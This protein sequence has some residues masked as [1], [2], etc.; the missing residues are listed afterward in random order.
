M[1]SSSKE[2]KLWYRKP[3]TRW[4]E[5]L[6]VGN[7]RLGAMIYGKAEEELIQLN[8]DSVW[9]GGPKDRHNPDAAAYFPK[10]RQL[11]MDGEVEE[12]QYLTRL[13]FTPSSKFFGPYQPLGDL[14]LWFGRHGRTTED[15]YRELDVET[16]IV[17]VEYTAGGVS[18]KREVFSSAVDQVLAVRITCGTPGGLRFC[19]NLTRRP[20]DGDIHVL[21]DSSIAMHGQ[22]GPDGIK[23]VAYLH[24]QYEG[25]T[26]QTI[27]DFI[28]IENADAVTLWLAAGTTFRSSDPLGQCI[29]QV[30]NALA[31]GYE[32]VK[33]EHITDHS[34]A[35]NRVSL[36]LTDGQ[37]SRSGLS[38]DERLEQVK[39]GGEDAGLA[40][41][42][43]QYGRYLLLGSSRPGTLPANL[44]GIWNDNYKPSW[45]S[46]YTTNINLQMNYWPAEV[47]NLA[48]CHEALFDFIDRL[49]VN[50]RETAR[51]M[52]NCRGFVLHHNTN[53]WADTVLNGLNVRAATWP[54]AG[55][56]LATHLWEHY[57]YGGDLAFLA[58]RAYPVM[59]EAAEFYLDY[60]VQDDRGRYVTCPSASPE[61]RYILPNGGM[62]YLT[63][64]PTMDSQILSFLFDS[65]IEAGTLLGE[66]GEFMERLREVRSQLPEPQLGDEGQLL[67]WL[68]D[69][70]EEDKGHRH[71]SHL[72]G[73]HPGESISV[74]KTPEL[75]KAARTTLTRRLANG[76]GHTGWSRCWIINFWARLGDG[77]EAHENIL[78]LLRKSTD[79]NLFDEHPPFQIDGNFGGAA[80]IA[81]MLL[82]SHSG[83]INLLPALPRA[84]R[85]GS[86]SG[87]RA[88]G[89]F[90]VDLSWSSGA[91]TECRLQAKQDGICR[92]RAAVPVAVTDV[93]GIDV[94]AEQDGSLTIFAA[95]KGSSYLVKPR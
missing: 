88:R 1:T 20:F 34:G 51:K 70:E 11:I 18:Y 28:S 33:Q 81:E 25:G 5:A 36:E 61:N 16:G 55:A 78:A 9:Y 74:A 47:G 69:Y 53:I 27:G 73:L 21:G 79:P 15:Y 32:R 66:S 52:Y 41:L 8:E 71:I 62:G 92:L 64:G 54:T 86:F 50:G 7:G 37:R 56:W 63:A 44:Q 83:E 80:G 49:R 24:A 13:A 2:M 31:K 84:W 68:E 6:P 17:R 72:F 46:N 3:A 65:C 95:E 77:E 48:E 45:E 14:N 29:R 12:A 23:Y 22:C 58:H 43:F 87:L 4:V 91:L 59:K 85:S 89:G 19:A 38:T 10:I 39:A 93:R 57:R 42:F 82:Q 76:G 40:A 94:P 30:N 35:M 75:A 26:A 67:E 90:E 60:M